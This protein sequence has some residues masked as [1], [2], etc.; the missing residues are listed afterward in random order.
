VKSL[1]AQ[2]KK[3]TARVAG[4]T[5]IYDISVGN[6]EGQIPLKTLQRHLMKL[7]RNISANEMDSLEARLNS[8][9]SRAAAMPKGPLPPGAKMRS[10]QRTV[11]RR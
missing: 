5:P 3:R 4:K 11:R 9:G 8:L 1:I 2:E 7:P 10:V 6:E